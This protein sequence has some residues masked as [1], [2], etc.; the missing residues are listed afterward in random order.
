MFKRSVQGRFASSAALPALVVALIGAS[1]ATPA[2]ARHHHRGHRV[3][4]HAHIRHHA[5]HGP[6]RL[7]AAVGGV[8]ASAAIVVDGAT[9]RVL[10]GMN[11]DAP[12]HPASVTK[13]MTLYLLFEQL[14]KGRFSLDSEI[15][16]SAHAAAQAPSKLG[17]R[18]GQSIRVEDA[19]KAIVTKSANDIAVAVGEAVADGPE[20]E[21]AELMT[22]KAHALGMTHTLYRN[23]SGLPNDEQI[24]TASDLAL[25]GRAIQD[26]FPRYYRYFSIHEF[27]YRGQRIHN[28][29]RLMD[30]CEGMDGIKTGYT[31]ASGFNLLSSVKRDGHYI[32]SVVMGGKSARARDNFMDAL[33]EDHIQEAGAWRPGARFAEQDPPAAARPQSVAQESAPGASQ[34]ASQGWSL[35]P[36]A[37]RED[38]ERAVQKEA[39]RGEPKV[40]PPAPAPV[41][42]VAAAD[43]GALLPIAALSPTPR[44]RPAYV[45][46]MAQG[47][48]D[49]PRGATASIPRHVTTTDGSTLHQGRPGS[50]SATPAA[51]HLIPGPSAKTAY[52]AATRFE[53]P[54]KSDAASENKADSRTQAKGKADQETVVQ[55]RQATGKPAVPGWVIQ[56]GATDDAD[57]AAALLSKAR[58]QH[59]AAL[60]A[61]RPFTEMIRKGG[62]TLYRARFAGLEES[63]AEAACKALKNSGFNCFATRN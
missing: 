61:A 2:E 26:R 8:G 12:R 25:L 13:V 29:N 10:Y 7:Q 60:G 46:A 44:P 33:I 47:D 6:R 53:P 3:A 35:W 50:G 45:S 41:E 19:I 37:S 32:V 15:P 20:S 31:A 14:E 58:S 43:K 51:T 30:R 63:K 24:T 21:F 59:G 1:V 27:A 16:I 38:E 23:A 34:G 52:R 54:V 22:R 42:R 4:Y 9:G 49:D 55:A 48:A 28:H 18:P 62:G 17:L 11:E 40:A 56:I 36:K 57:K 5:H 39:A